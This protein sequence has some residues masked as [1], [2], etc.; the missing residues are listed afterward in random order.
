MPPTRSIAIHRRSGDG[1]AAIDVPSV[2]VTS[3]SRICGASWAASATAARHA[4]RTNQPGVGRPSARRR[5]HLE[6]VALHV[7]SID[8]LGTC[9]SAL[10][11]RTVRRRVDGR[12][13]VFFFAGAR[14]AAVFFFGGVAGAAAFT[15]L[16]G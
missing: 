10:Y 8:C 14:A 4:E 13:A 9:R 2:S 15:R 11:G 7:L 3:T 1:A 5:R 6:T 16:A 12:A